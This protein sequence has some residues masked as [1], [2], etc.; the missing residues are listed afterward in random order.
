M[1]SGP[2]SK[3]EIVSSPK[4]LLAG[5]A[6]SG[7]VVVRFQDQ[8]GNPVTDLSPAARVSAGSL[9][10][11]SE[12]PPGT[13]SFTL[14]SGTK[15]G[16]ARVSIEVGGVKAEAAVDLLKPPAANAIAIGVGGQS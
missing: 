1:K 15:A 5:G 14:R 16:A 11:A 7:Q 12:A 3:A 9:S 4:S 13:Y 2:P 6:A 10:S 8:W